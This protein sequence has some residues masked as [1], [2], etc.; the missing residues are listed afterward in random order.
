MIKNKPK[1]SIGMP[2]YNAGRYLRESLDSLISQSFI[3]F[4]III[5]DNAS[6]DN[7]RDICLEYSEKDH[8]IRYIR[9]TVNTGP[10]PNFKYVLDQSQADYFMWAAHDDVKSADFIELNYNFLLINQD[11]VA[12]TCPNR[13]EARNRDISFSMNEESDF[14]RYV[15]FFDYCWFSHGIFYSLIRRNILTECVLM[16]ESNDFF[17][18]DWGVDIF[19]ASKGKI[20]LTDEGYSFFHDG[21]LSRL[22]NSHKVVRKSYMEL[23]IPYYKLCAYII[24]LTS[25][26]SLIKLARIILILLK[27][28]VKVIYGRIKSQVKFLFIYL[29]LIKNKTHIK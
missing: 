20:N 11:Y 21:G 8:R 27:L 7:T 14:K 29:K 1:V 17:G 2:I 22:P 18:I 5:S 24:S 4:E 6:T 3:D 25:Y 26:L 15:K 13:F 16:E 9:Q 12:S 19:L 10:W 28:N 23:I